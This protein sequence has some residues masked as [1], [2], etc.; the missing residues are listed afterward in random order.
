MIHAIADELNTVIRD[1]TSPLF[2][3][4]SELGR[5]LYFPKGILSQGAEAREK[6]DRYN[7]TVGIATEGGEGMH[8]PCV[9]KYFNELPVNDIFTYAPSFGIPDLRKRWKQKIEEDTPCLGNAEISLPVVTHALT[10]GLSVCGDMFVD[11]GDLVILPDK[12]WG[13]Y[14]LIFSVRKKAELLQFPFFEGRHFNSAAFGNTLDE[15]AKKRKKLILILNFPNNPTG[16][17][18]SSSEADEVADMLHKAASGGTQIAVLIDDAYFGL[19]Y[20][21]ETFKE[22]LFGKLAGLHENIL[23]VKLDG[24]TKEFY[25]WGFRTGFVTYGTAGGTAEV[26]NALEKKTAGAVRG[27]ISN[28]CRPSQHILLNVLS[29]P[30]LKAQKE[31]KFR[32]MKERAARVRDVIAHEKYS[33]VWDAYPFNSGY[34]MCLK[35]KHADAEKVRVHLLEKYG[36]GIIAVNETDVRVAFSC[37]EADQIEGLFENIYAAARETA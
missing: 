14:K 35:L 16:Y 6:A 23:A 1:E 34:F 11:P 20:D 31:E 2:D 22:S 28:C 8:L 9:R 33:E 13:N 26:Y 21:E 36:T 37:L 10:H 19:F 7:A 12:L 3:M 24:A 30:E 32:V 27:S 29:D 4:L 17:S 5:N 15:A 25:M 18:L